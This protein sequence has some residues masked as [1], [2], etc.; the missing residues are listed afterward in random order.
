MFLVKNVKK[1][2]YSKG[3]YQIHKYAVLRVENEDEVDKR[4]KLV[5]C[6]PDRW[7]VDE[8]KSSCFW[9]PITGKLFRLRAINCEKPEDDSNIYQCTIISDGHCKLCIFLLFTLIQIMI[10]SDVQQWIQNC[11]RKMQSKI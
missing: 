5:E 10:C 7:F 1:K 9:P 8:N 2:S 4:E 3:K 11:S 6:I